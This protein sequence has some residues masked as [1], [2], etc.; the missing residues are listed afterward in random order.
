[1]VFNLVN[2]VINLSFA[3]NDRVGLPI[4][5]LY[6]VHRLRPGWAIVV[7]GYTDRP[8]TAARSTNQPSEQE[9]ERLVRRVLGLP[10]RR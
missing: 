9:A 8:M 7:S 10:P 3:L 5:Y 6:D 2:A 4:N 1:M